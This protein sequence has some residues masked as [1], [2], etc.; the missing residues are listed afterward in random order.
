M[1]LLHNPLTRPSI[2]TTPT[3]T[4]TPSLI[5]VAAR[6]PTAAPAADLLLSPH[7]LPFTHRSAASAHA[8]APSTLPTTV[9]TSGI[10]ITNVPTRAPITPPITDPAAPVRLPPNFRLPNPDATSSITS[11]S[12]A[13]AA[14][15]PSVHHEYTPGVH[16]Q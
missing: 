1:R 11:P 13:T 15:T 16:S 2:S 14:Q 5:T 8:A 12:N 7:G 10:G 6:R 4:A 9:P 3:A